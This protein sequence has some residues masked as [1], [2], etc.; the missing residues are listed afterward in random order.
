MTTTPSA[1]AAATDLGAASLGPADVLLSDG[2]VGIVRPLRPGDHAALLALHDEVGL[3][4]LRLRF[5]S[6]S[7]EAAH[8]YVEHL[9][10]QRETGEVFALALWQHGSLVGLAT[11][12][13]IPEKS[14]AEVSFL[15]ADRLRGH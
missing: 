8:A 7:R 15:V 9:L 5:F 2:S 3:H 4:S 13:R 14:E 11:A 6:A 10:A 1:R 12:E